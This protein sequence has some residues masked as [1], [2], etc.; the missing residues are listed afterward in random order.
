[1]LLQLLFNKPREA[2]LQV[3]LDAL[4]QFELLRLLVLELVLNFLELLRQFLVLPTEV[5][6]R[7]SKLIGQGYGLDGFRRWLRV[8]LVIL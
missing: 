7:F 3:R 5:L 2:L 6:E 4:I 1:M 8:G